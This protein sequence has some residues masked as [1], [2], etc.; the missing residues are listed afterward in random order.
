MR[1]L[2][3]MTSFLRARTASAR[4]GQE[5]EEAE[6]EEAAATSASIAAADVSEGGAAEG[7]GAGAAAASVR[8]IVIGWGSVE[9][10]SARRRASKPE[11]AR[12]RVPPV[13]KRDQR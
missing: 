10:I 8:I 9:T 11:R 2:L 1:P 4:C 3:P 7:G 12:A 13:R 6:E 5:E